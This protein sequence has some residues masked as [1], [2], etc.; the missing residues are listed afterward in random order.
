MYVKKAGTIILGISIGLWALMYFPGPENPAQYATMRAEIETLRTEDA[1]TE[2]EAQR[3][4][5]LVEEEEAGNRLRNS[6]AGRL[7][8]LLE[9]ISRIAGF[10]WKENVALIG[11]VAAKEIVVGTL[12][13]AYAM[14]HSPGSQSTMEPLAQKLQSSE[15]W[16]RGKAFAL[17]IFVMLYAPCA[18]TLAVIRKETGSTKTALF[19]LGFSSAFAFVIAAIIY[20]LSRLF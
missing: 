20:H 14:D 11:G 8:R 5:I 17:M 7:G 13:T 15:D 2:A 19:S 10:G 3:R 6:F 9:P 18:A 1:C 16:S 4:L 12:S